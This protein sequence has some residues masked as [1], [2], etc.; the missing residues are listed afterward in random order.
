MESRASMSMPVRTGGHL[1]FLGVCCTPESIRPHHTIALVTERCVSFAAAALA[2]CMA[3]AATAG[4]ATAHA[5]Y[6]SALYS[7]KIGALIGG[8]AQTRHH[9]QHRP[10][11]VSNLVDDHLW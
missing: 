9:P 1:C 11:V 7:W 6:T 5:S 8:R 3:W 2:T 10:N 4:L